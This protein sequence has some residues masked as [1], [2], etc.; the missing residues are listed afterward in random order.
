MPSSVNV[1][2]KYVHHNVHACLFG[3]FAFPF[4]VDIRRHRHAV[5]LFPGQGSYTCACQSSCFIA[6]SILCQRFHSILAS[7]QLCVNTDSVTTVRFV[8]LSRLVYI[9]FEKRRRQTEATWSACSGERVVNFYLGV[10]FC[11]SLPHDSRGV[12]LI[13]NQNSICAAV[14]PAKK[15]GA[16]RRPSQASNPY[17]SAH[18]SSKSWMATVFKIPRAHHATLLFIFLPLA[19]L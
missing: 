10:L 5:G 16:K 14:V 4:D 11:C 12:R 7:R 6:P 19:C 8:S 15:K 1:C 17:I 18:A 2:F 13:S 9:P 3:I